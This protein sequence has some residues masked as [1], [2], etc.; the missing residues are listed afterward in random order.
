[1]KLYIRWKTKLLTVI[2][3]ATNATTPF[4]EIF[5]GAPSLLTISESAPRN[6]ELGTLIAKG[7][8]TKERP[9]LLEVW[10]SPKFTLRQR[11]V[12]ER[13]SEGTLLLSGQ[14]DYETTNLY[15]L[16]ILANDVWT[17]PGNDTR[18]IVGWPLVVAVLDEQDTPPVF[19]LA[20][21][22]TELHSD[23][24]P[25][26][27]VMKVRAED[28][29]RGNPRDIRYGLLPEENPFASFFVLSENAG[30]LRL[31][32][33]LVELQARTDGQSP[34]V[35]SI[36]AEEIR[37]NAK[38][39]A[40]QSTTVKVALIP[41]P[42]VWDIPHFS[43]SR[44]TTRLE[45]NSPPGTSLNLSS[46][47]LIVQPGEVL[48]LELDN[49]NGT[50][51]V[52]P[53]VIENRSKFN[54]VV[55]DNHLLDYESR[56]SVE[57]V[58]VAREFKTGNHSVSAK[59]VIFLVDVNDNPPVFDEAEYKAEVVENADVGTTVIHVRATDVDTG[60]GGTVR[61]VELL[62]PG[63]EFFRLDPTSGLVSVA[64]SKGLDAER[65]EFFIFTVEAA[66]EDGEGLKATTQLSL[67]LLDVNDEIPKFE[68]ELYEFIVDTQKQRFTST[69][70]IKAV[71]LDVTSPNNEVHYELIPSSDNVTLDSNTGELT[72]RGSWGTT[73]LVVLKARAYDGGVPRLWSD[74]EVRI[75]PPDSR[76]YPVTFIVPGINQNPESIEQKLR[77]L[78]GGDVAIKDIQ[79]YTDYNTNDRSKKSLVTASI[80]YPANAFVDIDRIQRLFSR[81][82]NEKDVEIQRA[83]ASDNLWWL[84]LILTLLLLLA[85]VLLLCCFCE[86]CPLYVPP[87]KRKI[88]ASETVQKN[89][90]DA[91]N[92]NENKSVQVAEWFGR[93]EAWSPEGVIVDNEV[94][95]LR[96]HEMERGSDRDLRRKVAHKRESLD[97]DHLYIREGNADILRLITRGGEQQAQRQ[98]FVDNQ[99][100]LVDSGK[101]ILLKRFMDQQ[102]TSH[103]VKVGTLPHESHR[104]YEGQENLEA[105][106]RQQ[107]SLLRQ[108]ILEREREVRLE[109]QSLPAGTQT[110]R[111][112]GTQTEE[113]YILRPPQRKIYSDNDASDGSEAEEEILLTRLRGRKKKERRRRALEIRRKITTPIREESEEYIE[114][115]EAQ[116]V[117]RSTDNLR[118][119]VLKEILLNGISRTD[120]SKLGINKEIL[121]EI[122]NSLDASE[123]T[124][125]DQSQQK[126]NRKDNGEYSS[127]SLEE[128]DHRPRKS[129]IRFSKQAQK[130]RSETDL[131]KMSEA[132]SQLKAKSQS[133]LDLS[134]EKVKTKSKRGASRYMEW[135]NKSKRPGITRNKEEDSKSVK[136]VDPLLKQ[137]K[138]KGGISES[139]G[140]SS[141]KSSRKQRHP[142]IQHS[143]HRF[144]PRRNDEDVDSGI[145]LAKP[146][147]T[148]RK[149][150]FSIAYEDIGTKQLLPDSSTP[151]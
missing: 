113:L 13:S 46:I 131:S 45:E 18:N 7:D 23:L 95:S 93:R 105:V 40:A 41:P 47:E 134:E 78:T 86:P 89:V 56:R 150:I 130:Y 36:I 30:E 38:E 87:N 10:G 129:K 52:T 96:R 137:A 69:A 20:P 54:I 109:T 60:L 133:N 139:S 22:V 138:P 128:G 117:F 55:R 5:P 92:G 144:E 28:G 94:D 115:I 108:I 98:Y 90:Q 127:D 17:E 120:V 82:V 146:P 110:D 1:M 100:N 11:I 84:F 64:D 73:E 124:E 77:T 31:A 66:D 112:A 74:T 103:Q 79:P 75:Y 118:G 101:D 26:D 25:G 39:P 116:G 121:T 141:S 53:S 122:F 62:G 111:N 119:R 135:Y 24:H 142:L 70:F 71:D 4:G 91:G 2:V 72:L 14:L 97:R 32:R 6:T 88:V 35:L 8:K 50:F 3:R 29:D 104:A 44:F 12:Q 37:T 147:I 80:R 63:S 21:P 151:T 148:Q 48:T 136:V 102:G 59:L 16:S 114:P 42:P 15:Y 9:V 99:N 67:H 51:E 33:P 123:S 132:K 65:T 85:I 83:G 61:Y 106:L 68:K 107:N 126:R 140:T 125:K 149:S 19:T 81:T 58:I 57:C 145:V 143:E 34:I 43:N 27:L 49:N 76:T